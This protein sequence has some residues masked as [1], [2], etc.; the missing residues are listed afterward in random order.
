MGQWWQ[1]HEKKIAIVKREDIPHGNVLSEPTT[2]ADDVYKLLRKRRL[3][4][5]IFCWWFV[6]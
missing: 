1:V 2:L 5:M 6:W 4:K 3:N